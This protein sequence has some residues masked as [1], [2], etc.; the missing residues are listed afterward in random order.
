MIILAALALQIYMPTQWDDW[1]AEERQGLVRA[2]T[3]YAQCIN[4]HV[5]DLEILARRDARTEAELNARV[6]RVGAAFAA[7]RPHR[8]SGQEQAERDLPLQPARIAVNQRQ[9]A[10]ALF[11]H[12]LE[13]SYTYPVMLGSPPQL[14]VPLRN[15]RLQ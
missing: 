4:R 2:A 12:R 1:S 3:P 7:C 9:H 6:E 14:M 8:I 15:E 5:P 10:I 11:F 13:D